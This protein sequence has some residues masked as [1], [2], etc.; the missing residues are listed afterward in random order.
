MVTGAAYTGCT[1]QLAKATGISFLFSISY[2]AVYIALLIWLAIL[3][4]LIRR[5]PEHLFF[6][7]LQPLSNRGRYDA[8]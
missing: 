4:G 1:F 7:R 8:R 6:L 2:Y 3:N 5:L